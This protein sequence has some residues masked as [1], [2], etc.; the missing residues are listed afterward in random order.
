MDRPKRLILIRHAESERNKIKRGTTYFADEEARKTVEGRADYKIGITDEGWRQ[1]RDT[2]IYLRD[3]FP[4]PEYVYHSGFER[5]L[6]T[7]DGILEAYPEEERG[8]IRIRMNAALAERHPG[9]GYDMTTDQAEEH[10]PY[11]KGYWQT[12]GG[13]FA[14]PPGGE[15]LAQVTERVYR[16]LGM[17][18]RDR[19]G[20]EVW[21]V[22]HGGTL[23]CFRFL[24]EHWDYDQ[25]LAWP[26]G[27]SPHNCGITVYEYDCN[28]RRLVLTEYNT[29]AY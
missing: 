6:R 9:Y 21:V 12:F 28:A 18:F 16:F 23:R 15:S 5:T 25:A 1:A 17:L 22:T 24:L 19:A 10:F 11:L 2:G 3:R 4:K 27:Q 20:E 29:K 26:P 8:S 13:F 7:T 14:T